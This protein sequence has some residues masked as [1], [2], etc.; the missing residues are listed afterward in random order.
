[1]AQSGVEGTSGSGVSVGGGKGVTVA[2]ISVDG[3]F[4]AAGGSVP[5]EPQAAITKV[6]KAIPK[7]LISQD[8]LPQLLIVHS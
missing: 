5:P 8:P 7:N 6:S 4:V 1:M 2:A 3:G